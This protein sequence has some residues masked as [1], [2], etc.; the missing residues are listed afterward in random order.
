VAA[1]VIAAIGAAGASA[2]CVLGPDDPAG[3]LLI[4]VAAAALGAAALYGFRARPRLAAD[5][6]GIEVGGIAGPR[7]FPWSAV[8]HIR[9]VRTRRFG[10]E[11]PT[12]EIE[13][14]DGGGERLH[15]FSRLE[16]GGVE[17][18]DVAE[19]LE[20]VRSAGR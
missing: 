18:A 13:T 7:R 2:W 17:P 6:S 20:A 16:L 4:G 8:R 1:V 19:S 15:V 11:V 10:R 9:V 14:L 3:R 5:P 12:L